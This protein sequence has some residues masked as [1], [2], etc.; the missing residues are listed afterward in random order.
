[1]GRFDQLRTAYETLITCELSSDDEAAVYEIISI[2]SEKVKR[3]D[4]KAKSLSLET[5]GEKESAHKSTDLLDTSNASTTSVENVTSIQDSMPKDE[6]VN[7]SSSNAQ[8]ELS[9]T[10]PEDTFLPDDSDDE[11]D[12]M[13]TSLSADEASSKAGVTHPLVPKLEFGKRPLTNV[14]SKNT[15]SDEVL[16]TESAMDSK[17][18][19]V[20]SDFQCFSKPDVKLAALDSEL[21]R[22]KSVSVDATVLESIL[23]R[24]ATL[25]GRFDILQ[26]KQPIQDSNVPLDSNGSPPKSPFKR[27]AFDDNSKSNSI[28][29]DFDGRN[30]PT[31]FNIH[32][33]HPEDQVHFLLDEIIHLSKRIDA[34]N[35][36][37]AHTA[38]ESKA[39]DKA[40]D[41]LLQMELD[42][43]RREV[44]GR[45]TRKDL[46]SNNQT[47]E[48]RLK[49][50]EML[51]KAELN[52]E[53]HAQQDYFRENFD[54]VF[55]QISSIQE[56]SEESVNLLNDKMKKLASQVTKQAE[57]NKMVRNEVM[58]L[59]AEVNDVME[60][61][62]EAAEFRDMIQERVIAFDER[63]LGAENKLEEYGDTIR[64]Q[65]ESISQIKEE[66]GD[67]LQL[68][69][70]QM[71]EVIDHKDASRATAV[72]TEIS[73]LHALL[74]V[75]LEKA[76]ARINATDLKLQN[77]ETANTEMLR[78]H[79]FARLQAIE[80]QVK[81]M[82]GTIREVL[83]NNNSGGTGSD[84][85]SEVATNL[86]KDVGRIKSI[87]F[88]EGTAEDESYVAPW[89]KDI[90]D[91]KAD[92]TKAI[93]SDNKLDDLESRVVQTHAE[94]EDMKYNHEL[95]FETFLTNDDRVSLEQAHTAM[96]AKMHALTGDL[97]REQKTALLRL[98]S[99]A[100]K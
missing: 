59:S 66:L 46:Q 31:F 14:E 73:Q 20:N 100:S 8:S 17:V 67:S 92:I 80:P 44:D 13:T 38:E 34:N 81:N 83:E 33:L 10:N 50:T 68:E 94:L 47:L 19:R 18:E 3:V 32:G 39:K 57:G 53:G 49:N 86:Q 55:G 21:L 45:V 28:S 43:I 75:D 77:F 61:V 12:M 6:P 5:T 95:A 42:K 74:K 52:E 84:I 15:S 91:V 88:G 79:V 78:D 29:K 41:E 99:E 11:I 72:S 96:E 35:I 63:H 22:A 65:K 1:M 87:M 2:L 7:N 85:M 93:M 70:S 97:E 64:A 82:E 27:M 25:E 48:L 69:I 40:Q 76:D 51:L 9:E 62:R 16:P 24:L 4:L 26:K 23:T 71:R 90:A 37:D 58:N 36:A 89:T 56:A 54:K 98:V 60:G 30:L